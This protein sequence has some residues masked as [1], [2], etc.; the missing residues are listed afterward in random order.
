MFVKYLQG[1]LKVI[2]SLSGI[3]AIFPKG[4]FRQ[5]EPFALRGYLFLP[6]LLLQ[7]SLNRGMNVQ[8]ATY[9]ATYI[10]SN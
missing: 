5:L 7:C 4:R 6:S 1:I 10:I 2:N 8:A 3:H 9:I